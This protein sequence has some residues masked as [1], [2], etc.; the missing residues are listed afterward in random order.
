MT[1]MEMMQHDRATMKEANA[2]D[3]TVQARNMPMKASKPK[4]HS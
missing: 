2:V 1:V 3:L 4:S